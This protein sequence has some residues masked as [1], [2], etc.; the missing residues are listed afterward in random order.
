MDIQQELEK[1][2]KKRETN[3]LFKY[4]DIELEN[5]R[6]IEMIKKSIK[7]LA[8]QNKSF[9]DGT[10]KKLKEEVKNLENKYNDIVSENKRLE[11]SRKKL[12]RK[13]IEIMDGIDGLEKYS[14]VTGNE[15]MHKSIISN[16]N[17]NTKLIGEVDIER[18]QTQGVQFDERVHNCRS[19]REDK[20][21]RDGEV[22]EEMR[23]GYL[24]ENQSFRAADV[25]VAKNE[26]MN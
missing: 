20:S 15:D 10:E 4:T 18:I 24:Y 21:R 11:K 23:A 12:V 17:R 16:V 14:L 26:G 19:T 1:Y 9:I 25:I 5:R 6:D 22:I 13:I 8:I 2:Y 3:E 7:K